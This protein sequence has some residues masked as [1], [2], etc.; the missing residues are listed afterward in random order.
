[1]IYFLTVNYYSTELLAKLINSLSVGTTIEYKI[2]IIN[3][4]P[5]DDS[6]AQLKSES[7]IIIEAGENLGFGSACNIGIRWIYTQYPQAIIWIINPDAYLPNNILDKVKPF[8]TSHPQLAIVGTIIYT[9][10]GKVW[11]AGGRFIATTGAIFTEDLLKNSDADYVSCDWVS[12]CS[13]I[14]NLCKF[15]DCP[16]FDPAYFLYYEDFDFCRRYANQ[17]YLIAVTKQLV[18][19]HQPSSITNRNIFLKTKHS[20]YSYLL[21]IKKYT[22]MLI[23]LIR[24]S[25]V[26]LY[27][28]ILLAIKPQVA[29]G[30]LYGVL[31]YCQRSL[32]F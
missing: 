21:T 24:L 4:S 12:G 28:L 5:N 20:T 31:I 9:P 32:K 29:F 26:I 11:F 22:N 8:F 23:L 19:L 10:I 15:D 27:A 18:V 17:G 3:N 6:I 13:L 30:K 2:V 14:I 1:M 25:R 7:V 16:W